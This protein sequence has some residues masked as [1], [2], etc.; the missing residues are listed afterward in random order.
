VASD[1]LSRVLEQA[2]DGRYLVRIRGVNRSGNTVD[3]VG[4][5]TA[6]RSDGGIVVCEGD[7]QSGHVHEFSRERILGVERLHGS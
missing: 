4:Y 2:H 5:V 6:L 1:A 3:V 7:S